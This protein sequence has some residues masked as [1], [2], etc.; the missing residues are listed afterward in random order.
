MHKIDQQEKTK[1][2]NTLTPNSQ[3]KIQDLQIGHTINFNYNYE[4]IKITGIGLIIKINRGLNVQNITVL[5][6]KHKMVIKL[7]LIDP[8]LVIKNTGLKKIRSN[9]SHLNHIIRK[10]ILHQ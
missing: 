7:S 8:T 9:K 10:T 3:H 5:C 2:L 6:K 4:K 1:I